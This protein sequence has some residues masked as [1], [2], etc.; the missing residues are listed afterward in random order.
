VAALSE[1][2]QLSY[3][4]PS[5]H[6]REG[7]DRIYGLGDISVGYR[8]QVVEEGDSKPAFAPEFSLILPSGNRD[9]GTGD[10][11]LGYEWTL[12]FSKKL[13]ARFAAHANVG[14]TYLP[15]VRARLD[16]TTG[17]LPPRRSL[18]SYHFRGERNFCTV[19]EVSSDA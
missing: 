1:D 16:G 19:P 7:G 12:P 2:H 15:R 6:V 10:G 4:I 18:V 9:R 5:F 13:N 8:Y 3:T 11:V 14:L 17:P